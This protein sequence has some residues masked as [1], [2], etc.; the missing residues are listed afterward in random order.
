MASSSGNILVS[1]MNLYW[2]IEANH[3]ITCVADVADSLDGKYFTLMGTHYVWFNSSVGAAAD[4]APVGFTA[5]PVAYDPNDSALVIAGLVQAAIDGD[6]AFSATVS[7][8]DVNVIAA[9]VGEKTDSADVDAGVTVAICRKGKNF[10]L[11]LLEGEPSLTLEPDVLDVPSQQTGTV[12]VTSII[13]GSNASVEV[14]MLETTKSNLKE[15]YK[16]YGGAFTPGAGTEVF[17]VGTG[18]IGKN[19]LV[20]GAR[21]EMIPVNSVSAEL[22]YNVN[23]MLTAPV[24][25]T[26]LFSGE[27]VR[28]MTVSFKGYPDLTKD[29]RVDT[30]LIGD[31]TQTGI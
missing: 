30:V 10:D 1:P 4:P 15:F 5:I 17:G 21:L 11:G 7:G 22:S 27:N 24:P 12:P 14:T 19:L 13:R 16:I 29:S 28:T 3:V 6:A 31:P 18:A 25:G 26:L 23:I 8:A 2:R 20:D 9:A